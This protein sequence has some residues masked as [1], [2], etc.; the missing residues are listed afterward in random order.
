MAEK[1][2]ILIMAAGGSRR[3][4]SCKLLADFRGVPLL[5]YALNTAME[6]ARSYPEL[7]SSVNAVLG[8]Y[9][10]EIDNFVKGRRDRVGVFRCP[11]WEM[12]LGHSLAF[13]VAQLP[14]ENAVLIMLADQPLIETADID[15]LVRHMG[16]NPGKMICAGFFST[17]GV[18]AVFPAEMKKALTQLQGDK[19]AKSVLIG[20]ADRLVAIPIP[21][22]ALDIDSPDDLSRYLK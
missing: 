11:D 10:D 22:A 16:Q 9:A 4:G 6:I 2:D 13:G 12:G 17:L 21:G 19:G 8:G 5:S 15:G 18:P 20:A 14:A 3:F 7:I 1:V